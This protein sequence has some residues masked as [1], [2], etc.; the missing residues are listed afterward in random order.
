MPVIEANK[1]APLFIQQTDLSEEYLKLTLPNLPSHKP[2]TQIHGGY[3]LYS[4][5]ELLS[6]VNHPTPV[7]LSKNVAQG[8]KV[9]VL[10]DTEK[11]TLGFV[12]FKLNH[13][14]SVVHYPYYDES[15]LGTAYVKEE[16]KK[17]EFVPA[18]ALNCAGEAAI[19]VD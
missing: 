14:K 9:G 11:G 2:F 3:G 13:A 4:V 18:V 15:Y 7:K 16:F 8:D 10:F 17:C 19:L 6:E 12:I 1:I 5:G